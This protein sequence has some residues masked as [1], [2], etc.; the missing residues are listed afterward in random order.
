MGFGANLSRPLEGGYRE[1]VLSTDLC[2]KR[3]SGNGRL[4]LGQT[5]TITTH[6]Y[7]IWRHVLLSCTIIVY[8][9][10]YTIT[11]YG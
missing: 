5:R 10:P 3:M 7:N 9:I 11:M 1:E 4:N 8:H 2:F 6:H